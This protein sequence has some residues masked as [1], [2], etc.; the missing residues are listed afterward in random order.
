VTEISSY[1][2]RKGGPWPR[3]QG[4][5]IWYFS[6][7]FLVEKCFLL[8][9]NWAKWNF[10]TV[11]PPQ[12]CFWPP[13]GKIHYWPLRKQIL[14]TP[15][16]AACSTFFLSPPG[17]YVFA[18]K[19]FSPSAKF[20]HDGI[21]RRSRR[22]SATSSWSWSR[23]AK[24]PWSWSEGMPLPRENHSPATS[25]RW[26][27]SLLESESRYSCLA[28][29]NYIWISPSSLTCKAVWPRRMH[30]ARNRKMLQKCSW[31][32]AT[33]EWT[34]L[35]GKSLLLLARYSSGLGDLSVA[36]SNLP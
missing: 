8:V 26:S 33:I 2:R 4:F 3:P 14:P 19:C 29:Q 17:E 23:G 20:F 5:Q 11:P 9:S 34:W 1:G 18:K 36:C 13:P 25:R 31:A 6:I 15:M 10:I 21:V 30:R 24:R 7:S 12:K 27:I 32:Q 22:T 35:K 16:S 28:S